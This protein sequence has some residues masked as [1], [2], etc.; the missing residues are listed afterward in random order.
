MNLKEV[1]WSEDDTQYH[2]SEI[3]IRAKY[4]FEFEFHGIVYRCWHDANGLET[5][6]FPDDTGLELSELVDGTNR[7][8]SKV[9]MDEEEVRTFLYKYMLMKAEMEEE[10]GPI[11]KRLEEKKRQT[12]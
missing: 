11:W 9:Y 2:K 8:I 6:T 7:L 5:F 3:R 10:L 1:I 12:K 4:S